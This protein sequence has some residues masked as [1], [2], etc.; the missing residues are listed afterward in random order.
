MLAHY[1]MELGETII[2]TAWWN[3]AAHCDGSYIVSPSSP[4]SAWQ[5]NSLQAGPRLVIFTA[6]VS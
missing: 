5:L 4:L 1:T 2:K 6:R 3:E